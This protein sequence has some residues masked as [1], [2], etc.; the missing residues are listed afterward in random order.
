LVPAEK[1]VGAKKVGHGA[2]VEGTQPGATITIAAP[3]DTLV[4]TLTGQPAVPVYA[5]GADRFEY[6][7]VAASLTFERDTAGRVTA[8]VLHQQ[9]LDMRAPRR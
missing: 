2:I 3:G 8:V 1:E 9:G 6:D 4:A 7:V 5:V